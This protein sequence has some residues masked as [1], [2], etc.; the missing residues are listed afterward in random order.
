MLPSADYI[1]PDGEGSVSGYFTMP[2]G[3]M[4]AEHIFCSSWF[5]QNNTLEYCD[6]GLSNMTV[7]LYNSTGKKLLDYT[8][9]DE[10]GN[11]YFN[12]LPYGGYVLDAEKAGYETSVSSLITLSPEHKH[13]T[14]VVIEL[15]GNKKI[16]MHRTDEFLSGNRQQV[17]PNPASQFVYLPVLEQA[18]ETLKVDL[19]NLLGQLILQKEMAWDS[20]SGQPYVKLPVSKLSPGVYFGRMRSTGSSSGFTFVKN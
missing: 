17:Y 19:Y 5:Q 4:F 10:N 9:T 13:E 15:T 8:L 20:K 6:G 14:G 2:A 7:F 1:L 11:F 16:G 18:T 12:G 3:Q